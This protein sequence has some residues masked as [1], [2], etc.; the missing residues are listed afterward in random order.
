M[1]AMVD[2]VAVVSVI[3]VV[4]LVI[5]AGGVIVVPAETVTVVILAVGVD[6]PH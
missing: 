3:A 1:L 5:R 4:A 6:L 2:V